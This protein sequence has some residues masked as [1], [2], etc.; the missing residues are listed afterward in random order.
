MIALCASDF[1]HDKA[2]TQWTSD[3]VAKMLS[4]S[5]WS[6]GAKASMQSGSNGM[7]RGG[8]MGRRGGIGGMGGGGMGR[9]GGYPGGGYPAGGGSEPMPQVTVTV[10]WQSALPVREALLRQAG[11]TK[12]GDSQVAARLT[13]PVTGYVIAVL[14]LPE[15]LP[16]RAGRYGRSTDTDRDDDAVG[17]RNRSDDRL[18]QLKSA[19]Y[20]N[21]K[22]KASLFP[23]KIERDKDGST[24][25]FTFA[26]TLPITLDDKEVEFV[27]RY[28][29]MEIKRKFKLKDMVY[30]G[31]LEL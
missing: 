3:E 13:A 29:P 30:Q 12:T 27:M 8:G 10:R 28:G 18:D 17:D 4:A 15:R 24:L 22:D 21:R 9:R 19:T 2:Y 14:G 11:F 26:R 25:L 20:L 6:Q 1:W 31:R 23:E 16:S 5:P 7:R